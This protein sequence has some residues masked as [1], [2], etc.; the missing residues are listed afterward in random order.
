MFKGYSNEEDEEEDHS[1]MIVK[2]DS[3]LEKSDKP[4]F[5]VGHQMDSHTNETV[6]KVGKFLSTGKCVTIIDTQGMQDTENRTCKF[7]REI[8]QVV[9]QLGEIDAF[10]LLFKAD[11][12]RL[13][14][15]VKEQLNTFQQL[16]GKRFWK[17]ALIQITFFS[18]D[19]RS[20][21]RR[22]GKRDM[23]QIKKG[24][25]DTLKKKMLVPY[26]V[27]VIFIDSVIDDGYAEDFEIKTFKEETEKLLNF[28]K[29]GEPYVCS[30]VTCKGQ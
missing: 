13:T 2:P 14:N 16:F 17:R 8:G 22:K 21:R 10:I 19:K 26:D 4:I 29:N 23:D 5:G 1:K 12:T 3:Y 6:W 11:T 15:V 25:E 30:D 9:R 28:T 27:P 18:H 7:T 24:W 20:R